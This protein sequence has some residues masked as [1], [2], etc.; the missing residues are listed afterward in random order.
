MGTTKDKLKETPKIVKT[1]T[2]EINHNF[3]LKRLAYPD[4]CQAKTTIEGEKTY[5]PEVKSRPFTPPNV[6]RDTKTGTIHAKKL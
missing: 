1:N 4:L 2:L 5:L 3:T 6:E